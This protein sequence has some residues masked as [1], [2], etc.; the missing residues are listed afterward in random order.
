MYELQ[1]PVNG[2]QNRIDEDRIFGFRVCQQI[3]VSAALRLKQLNGENR[4]G[5]L[6]DSAIKY[7]G[8]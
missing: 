3:G 2:L 1:V 8:W 5:H 7:K 4:W 6:S